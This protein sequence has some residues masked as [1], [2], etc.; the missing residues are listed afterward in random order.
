MVN[1]HTKPI[2]NISQ[3][4]RDRWN[5]YRSNFKSYSFDEFKKLC[6]E[7]RIAFPNVFYTIE[8]IFLFFDYLSQ[9]ETQ[10]KVFELGGAEGYL[11][12][13]IFEKYIDVIDKWTN[14]EISD[15]SREHFVC[16]SLKYETIPLKEYW[17]D[18]EDYTSYFQDHNVFIATHVFEHFTR[19]YIQQT[20]S[21]MK[22]ISSLQY[23]CVEM[24]IQED[25]EQYNWRDSHLLQ[26]S[27]KQI[28]SD[29][30]NN[31]FIPIPI[32]KQGEVRGFE[33]V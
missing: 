25:I 10:L 32:L 16:T 30:I 13:D 1:I 21:K 14:C 3:L 9:K 8:P 24:P 27:W 11:A 28:T 31:G 17:W 12:M 23:I 4:W 7:A 2:P 22:K 6:D 5:H 33:R 18:I 19:E 26:N 29:F 15:H 20:L